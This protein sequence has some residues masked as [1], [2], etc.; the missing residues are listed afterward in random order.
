MHARNND[1]PPLP[2]LIHHFGACF[3]ALT[4]SLTYCTF[5]CRRWIEIDKNL[6]V[7]NNTWRLLKMCF[8]PPSIR[9]P[10]LLQYFSLQMA[11]IN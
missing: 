10:P 7:L 5:Q 8:S 9:N 1:I 2:K 6:F 11:G 3:L 4:W